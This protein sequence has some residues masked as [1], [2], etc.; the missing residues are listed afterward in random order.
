MS[1]YQLDQTDKYCGNF[2]SPCLSYEKASGHS[3]ISCNHKNNASVGVTN[4]ASVGVTNNA[5]V[6]VACTNPPWDANGDT[7]KCLL[8]G[9]PVNCSCSSSTECTP[10]SQHPVGIKWPGC[11]GGH[12][13]DGR[14]GTNCLRDTDCVYWCDLL[15]HKCS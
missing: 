2:T 15:D 3:Y 14:T 10:C 4:N 1:Y 13:K 7:C 5:S 8:K 6:G 11:E 9:K 12:R